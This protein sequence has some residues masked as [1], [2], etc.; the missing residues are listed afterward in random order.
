MMPN[1]ATSPPQARGRPRPGFSFIE[2]L[3]AIVILGIGLVMVFAIFPISLD[4]QRR[5]IEE[6]DAQ[7]VSEEAFRLIEQRLRANYFTYPGNPFPLPEDF[8]ARRNGPVIEPPKFNTEFDVWPT[9]L[10][11]DNYEARA[12]IES[13]AGVLSNRIYYYNP[14]DPENFY[15]YLPSKTRKDTPANNVPFALDRRITQRDR[16]Y[17]PTGNP[18]STRWS[19][20]YALRMDRKGTIYAYVFVHRR[21]NPGDRYIDPDDPSKRTLPIP[22]LASMQDQDRSTS[23]FFTFSFGEI[24]G[25]RLFCREMLRNGEIWFVGRTGNQFAERAGMIGRITGWDRTAN[26]PILAG[27]WSLDPLTRDA[28]SA[29]PY[30][31]AQGVVMTRIRTNYTVDNTA[32][33]EIGE[34]D[35]TVAVY[36]KAL[37]FQN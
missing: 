23:T 31:R 34:A 30:R 7:A 14:Q 3:L 37:N 16:L 5:S 36:T 6:V 15:V 17:P 8:R 2:I 22:A 12:Y 35:P 13:S 32:G 28:T 18:E 10:W 4:Q 9:G 29:A 26:E 33:D 21:V 19:W 1:P 25:N 24:G 20:D 11:A 27:Q